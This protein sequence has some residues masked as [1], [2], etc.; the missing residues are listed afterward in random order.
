MN[1]DY[2]VLLVK[3]SEN[4]EI[5]ENA[6]LC[7]KIYFYNQIKDS[8]Y[9]QSLIINDNDL[10]QKSN[11]FF[12]Y[13]DEDKSDTREIKQKINKLYKQA[14]Q[15]DTRKVN[16]EKEER[17]IKNNLVKVLNKEGGCCALI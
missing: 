6:V 14:L 2:E 4:N 15:I 11:E 8:K 13:K 7:S 1:K 5:D 17:K 3:D 12:I 9:Y 16:W 10:S